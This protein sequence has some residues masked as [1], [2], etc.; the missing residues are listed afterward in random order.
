MDFHKNKGYTD[1]VYT[2]KQL[3]GNA[4]ENNKQTY[5]VCRARKTFD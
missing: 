2:I 3:S 4:T 1:V 5:R